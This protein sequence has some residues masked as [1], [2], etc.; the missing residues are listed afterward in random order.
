MKNILHCVATLLTASLLLSACDNTPEPQHSAD[1]NVTPAVEQPPEVAMQAEPITDNENLILGEYTY[2]ADAASFTNCA[3][4]EQLPVAHNEAAREL[5]VAYLEKGFAPMHSMP[6][7]IEG[8]RKTMEG[9]EPGVELPHMMIERIDS[10]GETENCGLAQ[11]DLIG[12]YWKLTSLGDIDSQPTVEDSEAHM[13]LSADGSV[14]GH[15]GCN[16]FF[17]QYLLDGDALGFSGIASTKM[18]CP[19]DNGV[20]FSFHNALEQ[21]NRYEIDDRKLVLMS[22]G[23]VQLAT[24]EAIDLQ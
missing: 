4:G 1:T 22:S 9:M 18:L 7:A 2:F 11:A 19:G 8:R 15:G 14:K 6:V 13:V 16:N 5:E 20:E 17:G 3:T 10:M 23:G 21:T 24:L 12:S